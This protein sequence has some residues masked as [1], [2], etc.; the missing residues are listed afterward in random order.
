METLNKTVICKTYYKKTGQKI[1]TTEYVKNNFYNRLE[2]DVTNFI[3]T[4]RKTKPSLVVW[5]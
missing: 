4:E 1:N 5:M 3:K 2:N